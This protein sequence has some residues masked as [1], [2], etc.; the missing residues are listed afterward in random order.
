[1]Q[2][3]KNQHYVPQLYLRQFAAERRVKNR[4]IYMFD[5]TTGR[6]HRP[7]IRNVAAELHFYERGDH[8]IEQWFTDIENG[9]VTP[10][11]KLLTL[12]SL[13]DMNGPD[14]ADTL[15]FLAAQFVR[16]REHRAHL[17]SIGVALRQRLDEWGAEYDPEWADVSDE[18]LRTQHVA[19]MPGLIQQCYEIMLHMK[20]VLMVNQTAMPLWTSDHPIT[21][22]NGI[23]AGLMGN[24]GLKCRGIEVHFPL[25]P[26]RSLCLCDP[27]TFGGLPDI[28]QSKDVN[29][30]M[31]VNSLQVITSTRFV[32][33]S[34]GDFTMAVD[35]LKRHPRYGDPDRLRFLAN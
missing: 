3:P 10:F 8:G 11:Q 33:G 35:I 31:F 21:L 2:H 1:M 26:R 4:P 28:L 6:V 13:E 30:V 27:V 29:H 18:T 17:K 34:T 12:Q 20:P 19:M 9:F 7:S 22:H 14:V 25:S 15:L 24:L 23:D 5:K 16:T 32:F